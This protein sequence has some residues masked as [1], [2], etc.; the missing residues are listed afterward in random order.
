[1]RLRPLYLVL[2]VLGAV[3]P[4]SQFLP[5]LAANGIDVPLFFRELFANKVAGA[6]AVDIILTAAVVCVLILAEGRRLGIPHLWLPI[7]LVFLVGVS[8]GLPLFLYWR[9]GALART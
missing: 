7:A 4:Y 9:E 2:C 1:M 6:F 8:C 3:L 5:W